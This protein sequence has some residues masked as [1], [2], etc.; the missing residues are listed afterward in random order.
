MDEHL[1]NL[2]IEGYLLGILDSE[3]QFK[4]ETHL[5]DC[6]NCR[7]RTIEIEKL[8]TLSSRISKYLSPFSIET[9]EHLDPEQ[10]AAY[11]NDQLE[12]MDR[13][14][15]ISHLAWCNACAA[16]VEEI[17]S[18]SRQTMSDQREEADPNLS[19]LDKIKI[20]LLSITARPL[21]ARALAFG[22]ISLIVSG[23]YLN[24]R[25]SESEIAK[26][27]SPISSEIS[28]AKDVTQKTESEYSPDRRAEFSENAAPAKLNTTGVNSISTT[29]NLADLKWI[30]PAE[31][32]LLDRAL[33]QGKLELPAAILE[34]RNK[35]TLM[36]NTVSVD[37]F[38]LISPAGTGVR[39]DRALL[40]WSEYK[41]DA[42]YDVTLRDVTN[43]KNLFEASVNSTELSLNFQ[44]ERGRLY[45]WQVRVTN[46]NNRYIFGKWLDHNFADFFV[47]DNSE[48]QRVV[49]AEKYYKKSEDS[50]AHLALAARYAKA[51]LLGDAERELIAFQINNPNSV[52]ASRLLKSLRGINRN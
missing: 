39:D 43:N 41:P 52:E 22:M 5:T 12:E 18:Y 30:L 42:K 33:K 25:N 32:L 19:G 51:G 20:F 46:P 35:D 4:A 6:Q 38:S 24:Y 14:C 40:K 13:E 27:E 2:I 7:A 11:V 44:L 28:A 37:S 3:E 50:L 31:R 23:I 16:E 21:F 8:T 9:T 47:L 17:L 49:E 45:R 48:L 26:P 10:I 34:M 29:S 1:S 15:A 36:G